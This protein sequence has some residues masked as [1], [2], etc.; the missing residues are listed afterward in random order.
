MRLGAFIVTSYREGRSLRE[1]A[2]LTDRSP[3]AVRRA[4]RKHQIPRR[5]TGAASLD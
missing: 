1:V 3:T 4:L 2:E 5:S